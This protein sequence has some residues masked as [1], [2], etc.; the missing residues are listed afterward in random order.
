MFKNSLHH[1]SYNFKIFNS[2]WCYTALVGSYWQFRTTYQSH[3]QGSS[4]FFCFTLA[5]EPNGCPRTSLTTNQHWV[6]SQKGED[7]VYSTAEAWYY[8]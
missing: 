4:N 5:D 8:A 1:T 3:L 2:L 7:L 6:K